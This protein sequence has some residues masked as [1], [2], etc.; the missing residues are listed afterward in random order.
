MNTQRLASRARLTLS[1]GLNPL[2]ESVPHA[3][4]V[5][6]CEPTYTQPAS[7]AEPVSSSP[8][9]SDLLAV[10]ARARLSSV[11]VLSLKIPRIICRHASNR[12]REWQ[13][14][15][16]CSDLRMHEH[17]PTLAPRL[18]EQLAREVRP[19]PLLPP[20]EHRTATLLSPLASARANDKHPQGRTDS[21]RTLSRTYCAVG[22]RILIAGY[23]TFARRV[24]GVSSQ[25][26]VDSPRAEM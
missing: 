23:G 19:L 9:L 14:S 20:A 4:G 26:C 25:L 2:P 6:L 5:K 15:M 13:R 11:P 10:D 22:N 7:F 18:V 17:A 8:S 12:Q 3:E 21:P 1:A 16:L 24:L